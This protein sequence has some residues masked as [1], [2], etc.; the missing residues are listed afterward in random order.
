MDNNDFLRHRQG[1]PEIQLRAGPRSATPL[2]HPHNLGETH[3][4]NPHPRCMGNQVNLRCFLLPELN[5]RDRLVCR[6]ALYSPSRPVRASRRLAP[7]I[8]L[9]PALGNPFVHLP[10]PNKSRSPN[11]TKKRP[12]LWAP[13]LFVWQLPPD[14]EGVARSC[15]NGSR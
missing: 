4:F 13:D 2:G 15:E 14:A 11:G 12:Q 5:L 10:T 1:G 6:L 3:F 8:D 7:T 9:S